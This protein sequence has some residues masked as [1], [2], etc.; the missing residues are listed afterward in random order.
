[1]SNCETTL[2]ELDCRPDA[3]L[4]SANATVVEHVRSCERCQQIVRERRAFDAQ[5]KRQ[6]SAVPIPK[7]LEDRLL[8]ALDR[9]TPPPSSQPTRT[10]RRVLRWSITL[11]S[12]AAVIVAVL[13]LSPSNEQQTQLA[14]QAV[15]S[16]LLQAGASIPSWPAF[17]ESFNIEKL[18]YGLWARRSG[19][20]HGIDLNADVEH[21]AAGFRFQTPS[22]GTGIV[23]VFPS[24]RVT[25]PPQNTLPSSGSRNR[26]L[27]WT[28]PASDLTYIC[29]IERGDPEDVLKDLFGVSV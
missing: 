17:D 23:F 4:E 21:D 15:E 29:Q 6:L 18:D 5:L 2:K 20:L 8:K 26:T 27:S 10:V 16:K 14:Y 24:D 19:R 11:A 7:G 22:G 1:M 13:W 28:D 25:D 9:S 12:A 3:D